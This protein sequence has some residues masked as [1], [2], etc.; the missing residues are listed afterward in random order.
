M[1]AG[2]GEW[3]AVAVGCGC[4]D[5]LCVFVCVAGVLLPSLLGPAAL[6]GAG[7]G[8]SRVLACCSYSHVLRTWPLQV[9]Y[10][11]CSSRGS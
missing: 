9:R 8:I 3:T 4:V 1:R 2:G 6:R 11:Y 5:A 7:I 10:Y